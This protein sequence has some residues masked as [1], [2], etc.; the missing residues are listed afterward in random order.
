MRRRRGAGTFLHDA[1]APW[2]VRRIAER[3]LAAVQSYVTG[4]LRRC[5]FGIPDRGYGKTACTRFITSAVRKFR[6][7]EWR[8]LPAR[9][10]SP[11]F[12]PLTT[13]LNASRLLEQK[14]LSPG[15]L[16]RASAKNPIVSSNIYPS[17]STLDSYLDRRLWPCLGRV[18]EDLGTPRSA[19]DRGIGADAFSHP[20]N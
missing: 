4:R 5:L 13:W 7:T 18:G 2:R 9:L 1:V 11:R 12:N 14:W 3:W 17:F 10:G 16:I 6:R 19:V 15:N 8:S 20:T